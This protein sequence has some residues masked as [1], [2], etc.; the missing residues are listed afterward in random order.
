ME[1]MNPC[2]QNIKTGFRRTVAVTLAAASLMGLLAGCGGKPVLQEQESPAAQMQPEVTEA[3]VPADGNPDDVTCKGSYTTESPDLNAQVARLGEEALTNGELNT[4]YRLTVN[5]WTEK[6]NSPD[7]SKPLDTQLLDTD[8]GTMTWQQFFLQKALDAWVN[9]QALQQKS[10]EYFEPIP[11]KHEEYMTDMPILPILYSKDGTYQLNEKEEK[12]LEE[13]PAFLSQTAENL[14]YESVD[15]M[16]QQEFGADASSLQNVTWL[17]NYSYFYFIS[18]SFRQQD[19]GFTPGG[20]DA[21]SDALVTLRH[22]LLLPENSSID[23]VGK[24]TAPEEEWEKTEAEA[25]Q[26]LHK[27]LTPN[28]LRAHKGDESEFAQLAHDRSRD[29]GSARTGGI[30]SGIRKGQLPQAID[31]WAFAPERQPEDTAV[32]RSEYG[33]HVVFFSYRETEEDVLTRDSTMQEDMKKILGEAVLAYPAE[34]QYSAIALSPAVQQGSVTMEQNLLYQDIGYERFTEVP[35]YLQQDYMQ[36]PY[37]AGYKVGTHGCGITSF[38]MLSTYMTDT[39]MTPATCAKQFTYFGGK[40][41]TDGRIFVMVPPGL[42]YFLVKRSGMWNEAEAAI[43]EGKKVICVQH[44]GYFTRGGHYLVLTEMTDD[45]LVVIRDSNIYNYKRLREHK[46]DKFKPAVVM[47]NCAGMW[48]FDNKVLTV[49]GCS[50]CGDGKER[51]FAEGYICPKCR[52][53]MAR[54][55]CFL[56]ITNSK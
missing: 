38:A 30:Y 48:I 11:E 55:D 25:Q 33:C 52:M 47:Q 34:I 43:R 8:M 12:F 26:L 56:E 4:L 27:F 39:R 5:A 49:P 46:V 44:K 51:G 23:P 10:L 24:V 9:M 20:A 32:L 7:F 16:A 13:I 54:R 50:R 6:E 36:A 42:G 15:A 14:G 45:D 53:A 3:T 41:G 37:A 18:H 22:I 17:M 2:V 1:K 31:S 28:S 29:T 19:A 21:S 35:V 40:G